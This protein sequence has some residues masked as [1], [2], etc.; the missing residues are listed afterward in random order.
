MSHHVTIQWAKVEAEHKSGV[1]GVIHEQKIRCAFLPP[2]DAETGSTPA[3]DS[4]FVGGSGFTNGVSTPSASRFDTVKSGQEGTPYHA[5]T[6]G[7]NGDSN[8]TGSTFSPPPYDTSSAAEPSSPSPASGGAP[9]AEKSAGVAG[10]AQAAAQSVV[11]SLPKS[12]EEV[13]QVASNAATSI[14]NAA[15]SAA[16]SAGLTSA[17]TSTSGT[18]SMASVSGDNASALQQELQT[19]KA[20]IER[21]KKLLAQKEEEL[22]SG[23]RQRN[24]GGSGSASKDIGSSGSQTMVASTTQNGIPIEMVA[25]IAA[26]VFVFTW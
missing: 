17:S 11:A 10:S 25:A 13:K 7:P 26:G 6:A 9:L 18:R 22:A 12:T 1:E 23:L 21:I 5:A 19:A 20:E 16:A 24:V 14:S 8:T 3:N 15:S 2:V 4:S